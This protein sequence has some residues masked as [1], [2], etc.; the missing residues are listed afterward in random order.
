LIGREAV[1]NSVDDL[2]D[3]AN[4]VDKQ[5]GTGHRRLLGKPGSFEGRSDR[6]VDG[7]AGLPRRQP[8]EVEC[9]MRETASYNGW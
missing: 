4:G 2:T 8:P 1:D 5:F 7:P 6:Q 9:K 3:P